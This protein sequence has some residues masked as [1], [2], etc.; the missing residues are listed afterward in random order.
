[1]RPRLTL[2]R[3]GVLLLAPALFQ[4][5]TGLAFL[6]EGRADRAAPYRLAFGLRADARAGGR[7]GCPA[8]SINTR[9]FPALA[10]DAPAR[11]R[12]AQEGTP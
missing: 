1:M 4:L 6:R 7:D 12:A 11:R 3:Q 9:T 5:S 8:G 10:Q 2:D